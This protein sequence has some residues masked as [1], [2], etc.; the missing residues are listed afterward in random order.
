MLDE[1]AGPPGTGGVGDRG[2]WDPARTAAAAGGRFRVPY[3]HMSR[4][5][6]PERM[7][8]LSAVR[9]RLETV[10]GQL[11]ERY[12][13]KRSWAWDL[14]HLWHLIQRVVRKVLSHTVR[15]WVAVRNG[16]GP[17]SFNHLQ[18]AV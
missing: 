17:L 15:A 6:D 13:L 3:Q 7:A 1:W 12:Q 9:Y 5:P 11:S 8:R 14:W 18:P 10:D 16:L 4:N 2:Y